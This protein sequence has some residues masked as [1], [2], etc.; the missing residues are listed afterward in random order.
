MLYSM[1]S[2]K[3]L[4]KVPHQKQ[5]DKWM[6][7]LNMENYNTVSE[8]IK[9]KLGVG[10]I[11]TSTF[12]PQHIEY[13]GVLKPV[14]V[15]CE[16]SAATASRFYSLLIYHVLMKSDVSVWCFDKIEQGDNPAKG[17]IYFK[18]DVIPEK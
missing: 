17:I 2:K 8:Y 5:F 6:E 15:A 11:D 14:L 18:L 1:K 12:L 9:S 13:E 16:N 10:D 3:Y 4:N 7:K